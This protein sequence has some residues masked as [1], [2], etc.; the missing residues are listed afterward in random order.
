MKNELQSKLNSLTM[1]VQDTKN[2]APY[3]N[4]SNEPAKTFKNE[5]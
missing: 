1:K 4:T 2:P 3:P 5:D